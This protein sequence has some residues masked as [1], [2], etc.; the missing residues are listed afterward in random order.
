MN[1]Y[2]T[3]VSSLKC[4]EQKDQS[5]V[6]DEIEINKAA[7][8]EK[9]EKTKFC[10]RHVPFTESLVDPKCSHIKLGVSYLWQHVL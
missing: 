8:S 1:R 9:K 2:Q 3:T 5:S 7:K 4:Y 10:S 6:S